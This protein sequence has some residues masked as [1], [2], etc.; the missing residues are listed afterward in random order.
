[1]KLIDKVLEEQSVTR[2]LASRI[3]A[4]LLKLICT[5]F[6]H[7]VSLVVT[8]VKMPVEEATLSSAGSLP[9]MRRHRHLGDQH[10]ALSPRQLH[11]HILHDLTNHKISC[12]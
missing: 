2:R 1:M 5:R 10:V 4:D 7:D 6:T 12:R 3:E 9:E 8:K 11:G